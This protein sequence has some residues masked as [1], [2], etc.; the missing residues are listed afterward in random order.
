MNQS[1]PKNHYQQLLHRLLNSPS[2]AGGIALVAA[3][4]LA[5]GWANSAWATA[6]FAWLEAPISLS[7]GRWE[8][9]KS[10]L[11]W[12]NDGLMGVFF[13]HVGLEIKREVMLGEL[14]SLRK[15]ALPIFAAVGGMVVPALIYFAITQGTPAAN[16][17]AV[18]VATDIA[19]ALGVLALMGN[20]IPLQLKV[21]V[22]AL[23]IVDDIGAVLIIALVHT[24]NVALL[25]LGIGLALFG[26]AIGMNRAGVRHALA[27][28]AV[29]LLVWFGFLKSGV[30]ATVAA[31]LMAFTIPALGSRRSTKLLDA[32][33]A[34]WSRLVPVG[35]RDAGPANVL[36]QQHHLDEVTKAVRSAGSPLIRLEHGL[37][38]LVAFVVLPLFAL[39][40]AGVTLGGEGSGELLTPITLASAA[41]LF[42]GKQLGVLGF[43]WLAVKLRLAELPTQLS[44]RMIHG[45]ALLCGIGF[46]MALFIGGLAFPDFAD[47][48]QAKRGVLLGSFLSGIGAWLVLRWSTKAAV[49]ERP[50]VSE[51]RSGPGAL[52]Y[53]AAR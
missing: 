41:G 20:R 26:I 12:I 29:G 47:Y 51:R 32:I 15:A 22:T 19:F 11:H 43:S 37:V 8:L 24:D 3:A 46:T 4:C 25:N 48:A 34:K 13:F 39:A 50:R 31:L 27:Y 17:W 23:A 38:P 30:H 44:W 9:S 16:G 7:F 1:S 33:P 10:T 28:L 5:L 36:E 6:Y 35:T 14:S 21:F 42:V 49:A 53:D 52:T 2:V 18:P 45:A 40:N